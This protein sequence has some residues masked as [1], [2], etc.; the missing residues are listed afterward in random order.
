MKLLRAGIL[1]CGRIAKRHA[2]ILAGLAEVDLVAFCDE[3][4]ASAEELKTQFSRGEVYTDAATMLD[5]AKLDLVYI[6]LPPY[7][8]SNEV[9]LACEH[10]VHFL[11]EKPIALTMD[12]AEHMAARVRAAGVKS[13]VGFMYRHGEAALWLQ[14]YMVETRTSGQG[15]MMGRYACNALHRSWWRDRAK[16]GG[17]LVEQVIHIVD[18][19][20][21]YLGEPAEVY[22]LQDNLFHRKVSDYTVEDVSVTIIRFQAG[23]I[24]T[25]SATNGAIPGRWDCDWRL[26]LPEL[27]ADF[28]DANHAVFHQT[29]QP[30][31]A[32]TTVAT[33]KDMF[34]AQTLDLLAAIRDDRATAVPIEEGVRSLRLALAATTS[35]QTHTPVTMP[36]Q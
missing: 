18:L 7:A 32:T 3:S 9:D 21:F 2:T 22:S 35:A 14:R 17:Q 13:Q 4:V 10:K 31:A 34:L 29:S 12:M 27:T 24:A 28:Q 1:G 15:F 25:I 6:C 19:A 16:S 30:W 5:R 11:I 36:A 8:H 33:D 23:G 26:V 20:R